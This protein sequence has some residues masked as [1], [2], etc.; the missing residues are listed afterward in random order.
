MQLV[1]NYCTHCSTSLNA[2]TTFLNGLNMH[3][4]WIS[5]NIYNNKQLLIFRQK[6]CGSVVKAGVKRIRE[7]CHK[8]ITFQSRDF[9]VTTIHSA[10]KL[11]SKA[12]LLLCTLWM[13]QVSL[14][15]SV[16]AIMFQTLINIFTD[17]NFLYSELPVS[18]FYNIFSHISYLKMRGTF[19]SVIKHYNMKVYRTFRDNAQLILD[20]STKYKLTVSFTY[21]PLYH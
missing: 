15:T 8:L 16:F 3:Y 13:S 11:G 14:P 12:L 6:K 18:S 4:S 9:L 20:H 17:L 21:Q 19:A 2:Y 1:R 10:I 5:V 7:I